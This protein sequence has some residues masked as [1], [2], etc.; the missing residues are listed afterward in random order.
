MRSWWS[1]LALAALVTGSQSQDAPLECF[2]VQHPVL[3]DLGTVSGDRL[4]DPRSNEENKNLESCQLTLMKHSFA[5]SYGHPFV[6][7]LELYMSHHIAEYTNILFFT[8]D[9]VPPKCQFNRVVM[10]FTVTS[11]GRQFDR[12]AVMYLGDN[13]IW[14]TST[15][16]PKQKPGIAWTYWK[17]MSAY[18]TLWKQPQKLIFDLGNLVDS[19]YTGIYNTTLTATFINEYPYNRTSPHASVILPISAERSSDD[20]GSAFQYPAQGASAKLTFPKNVVRAVASISATGQ[21][22]EEF[23]WANVGSKTN[24]ISDPYQVDT[25][26]FREV[27][28]HIDGQLAGLVWPFPVIFTGGIAPS[29]HR[30]LVGLQAFDLLESEIDISPWLGLLCD[31]QEHEFQIK[32]VGEYDKIVDNY[33]LL[34]GK[35]FVWLDAGNHQTRGAAPNVKIVDSRYNMTNHD[36][37]PGMVYGQKVK[38]QIKITSKIEVEG[39]ARPSAVTWYQRFSMVNNGQITNN[40]S[41]QLVDGWYE[42]ESGADLDGVSNFYNGFTYPIRAKIDAEGSVKA[43]FRS[44]VDLDQR[45]MTTTTGATVFSNGLQPF[46]KDLNF[47]KRQGSGSTVDTRRIGTTSYRQ[48][49]NGQTTVDK[50]EVEQWY[51]YGARYGYKQLTVQ[52]FRDYLLL[53]KRHVKVAAEAVVEDEEILTNPHYKAPSTKRKPIDYN[54]VGQFA[55]MPVNPEGRGGFWGTGMTPAGKNS[56]GAVKFAGKMLD[57]KYDA[58][59][60]RSSVEKAINKGYLHL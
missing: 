10:N 12:L 31:G 58:G 15:A 40:G 57:E 19:T 32:V 43:G 1:A 41:Y 29:L 27:Q 53:Y 34:T 23:W 44:N 7:K 42:G 59:G 36:L 52:N 14:R 18:L 3:T 48:D 38:R 16:E 33:W 54:K 25:T 60:V 22:N 37:G 2:Q 20:Q 50:E 5:F 46:I 11:E 6:G 51:Y 28:L 39:N 17:D 47:Q 21:S 30:P 49:A 4:L 9:Y 55:P 56:N 26:P 13:E 8:A 35:V 45:L 24:N